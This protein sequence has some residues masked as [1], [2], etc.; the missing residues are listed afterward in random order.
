MNKLTFTYK[1]PLVTDEQTK[2]VHMNLI[3][4]S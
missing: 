3:M 4:L 1:F 2:A